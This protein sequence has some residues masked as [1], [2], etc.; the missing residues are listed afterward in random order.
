M[1]AVNVGKAALE[2]KLGH[3]FDIVNL[4]NDV[5]YLQKW[6]SQIA[7]FDVKLTYTL[8]D[9]KISETI[10]RDK[11]FEVDDVEEE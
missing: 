5:D 2:E 8:L 3:E 7:S 1:H 10:V 11:N 6:G 9:W 4:I